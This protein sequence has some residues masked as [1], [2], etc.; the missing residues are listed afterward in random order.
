M[1][2]MD[3]RLYC[4]HDQCYAYADL[5]IYRSDAQFSVDDLPGWAV[6][7]CEWDIQRILAR[8]REMYPYCSFRVERIS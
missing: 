6:S 8:Y 5:L 1:T 3:R 7:S 2:F 4:N